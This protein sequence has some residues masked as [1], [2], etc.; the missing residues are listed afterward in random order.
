M[1]LHTTKK[2]VEPSGDISRIRN[3]S[4]FAVTTTDFV[5]IAAISTSLP[6]TIVR[7]TLLPAVTQHNQF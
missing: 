4:E 7:N 1:K 5:S 6:S 3:D 2:T